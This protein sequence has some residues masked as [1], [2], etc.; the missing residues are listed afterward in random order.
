MSYQVSSKDLFSL[1]GALQR[2]SAMVAEGG[3]LSLWK[4]HST[5]IG[6]SFAFV[7]SF[8]RSLRWNRH[9]N[10]V[11]VYAH[12]VRVAP[13][14]GLCYAAHDYTERR[15]KVLLQTDTLPF[16]YKF[17]AGSVGGTLSYCQST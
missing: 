6:S 1:R 16:I 17:I 4:G 14:A 3:V 9:N 5:T 13:Y 8:V 15:F 11:Y 2:G 12:V 7:R 10:Y